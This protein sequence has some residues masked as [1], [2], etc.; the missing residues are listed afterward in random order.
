MSYEFLI[1]AA[2]FILGYFT[3]RFLKA[4]VIGVKE[5]MKRRNEKPDPQWPGGIVA[6]A[7][8]PCPDLGIKI[9]QHCAIHHSDCGEWV[10]YV[11]LPFLKTHATKEE[12]EAYVDEH[13]APHFPGRNGDKKNVN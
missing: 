13:V 9:G 1:G 4:F 2:G 11:P 8:S 12:M 10:E 6:P 3:Y 7:G 5:G